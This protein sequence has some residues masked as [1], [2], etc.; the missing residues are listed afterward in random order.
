MF[1]LE[2][3]TDRTT[4][5]ANGQS[6]ADGMQNLFSTKQFTASAC[7]FW[8]I[9]AMTDPLSH[10]LQSVNIGFGKA[11]NLLDAAFAQ[12]LKLRSDPQNIIHAV[13]ENFDG[14]E[15]EEKRISRR[16]RMPCELAQDEPETSAEG[17]WRR[18]VFYAAFDSLIARIKESF[19]SSQ[20]ILEAFAIF[21]P[22][23]LSTFSE[24]YATTGH[25][26]QNVRKFCK[27]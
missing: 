6:T 23:A 2:K 15:W 27:T 16:R 14:I 9:F 4:F 20:H 24:V 5:D 25:V 26:K 18:E 17:K 1:M 7:L 13:E 19:S 12:L 21:S 10:I 11:L 3:I 22:K 8:E